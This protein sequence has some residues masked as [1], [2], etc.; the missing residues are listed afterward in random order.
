MIRF[1]EILMEDAEKILKWRTS[2]RIN[3][4]SNSDMKYDLKGHTKWL[5]SNFKKPDSYHW[6]VQNKGRDIG[7]LN[8]MEW[9]KKKRQPNGVYILEK[10]M[11]WVQVILLPLTS[12][13]LLSMC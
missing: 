2:E 7:Y 6:M 9:N 3:K 10:K 8:F 13:I 1:R 12:I 4:T 11:H 5:L